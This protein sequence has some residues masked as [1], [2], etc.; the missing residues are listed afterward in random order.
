MDVEPFFPRAFALFRNSCTFVSSDTLGGTWAYTRELVSGMVSRGLRV[1][2]VSFGEIP[3]PQ[4]TVVDGSSARPGIPADSVPARLDGRGAAGLC[5]SSAYLTALVKERKPDLLHLNQLCYG[6]LPVAAPRVVV[7]HGDLITWWK[8]VHGRAPKEDRWL[9]WYRETVKRGLAMASVVVAPSMWMRDTVRECYTQA[10]HDTV[11]YNG[12]NPI[13]FN[14]YVGKD[15]SVLAVGRLLDAGKQ[16]SLLTQHAIRS[17]CALSVRIFPFTAQQNTD[18]SRRQ[19]ID[20]RDEHSPQRPA[21]RGAVA[22]ALQPG[23]D[24]CGHLAL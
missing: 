24:L 19:A 11:I 17:P 14:P 6:S 8:A 16:V 18:S 3:L 9:Q 23:F 20:R 12:R 10:E 7:A 5:E 2:L 4:Q 15:D 21:D 1:T 22:H 13:F